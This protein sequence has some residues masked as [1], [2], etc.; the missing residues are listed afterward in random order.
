MNLRPCLAFLL[1]AAPVVAQESSDTLRLGG[2]I[3]LV[4][5]SGNSDLVTLNVG[6]ELAYLAGAIALRQS[7]TT[8]YGRADGET[9]ASSWRAGVRGDYRF[10]PRLATYARLGFD[11][12]R[13]AGISRRFEEGVGLAIVALDRALNLLE[14]E[15]GV[16]LVQQRATLDGD[17]N[18]VAGRSA[19]RYRRGFGGNGNAYFQQSLEMLPNLEE[20]AD[21]R[22]NSESV[23]VAPLSKQFA[24]KLSYVIRLDNRPEPGFEKTDRMLTSALQITL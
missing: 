16:D 19:A 12:D 6:E 7:F 21:F 5:T 3:G 22:F 2:T 13:F 23:L 1:L 9:N 17:N 24:L 10:S 11:R 4:Q 8:V 14:F 20:T 18:F 15:A